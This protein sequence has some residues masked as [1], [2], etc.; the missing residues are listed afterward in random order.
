MKLT[1]YKIQEMPLP[2]RPEIQ[3]FGVWEYKD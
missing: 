1:A 2:F 3:V